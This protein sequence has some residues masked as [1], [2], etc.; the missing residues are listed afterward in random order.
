MFIEQKRRSVVKTISWRIWATIT[1]IALVFLFVGELKIA[2][3]IGVFE[4]ILK[5]LLYFF[6]ERLWNKIKFG[7]KE[8][9]P[10]VIW[11]TGL[12]GSGKSTLSENL[13]EALKKKGFKVEHLDGDSIRDIFPK[14]GFSKEERNRH[15]RRVGFLASKLENN[16][17][18]VIASFI[19]PY[20][21]T[22]DFVRNL[23]SNFIEVHVATPLEIC[24][25]RDTKGLYKK[26]RNGEIKEFTGID[27]PYEIPKN[28]ELSIN[29]TNLTI[30]ESV[31]KVLRFLN[32]KK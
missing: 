29:T 10:S 1:T 23:C 12:S 6:H 28:P 15:I 20:Q 3:S 18:T 4:V 22:R 30:E 21:E 11:F 16:G 8:I 26:A 14:T 2:L 25:K 19:S 9:K 13:Y 7:K 31:T 27:D 17:I 32:L 24:E 5:M